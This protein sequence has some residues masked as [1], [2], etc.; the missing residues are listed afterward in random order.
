MFLYWHALTIGGAFLLQE[1]KLEQN[2]KM[3]AAI[4]EEDEL[5]LLHE[6]RDM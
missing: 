6:K 5:K 3:N 4:E 1:L 2:L